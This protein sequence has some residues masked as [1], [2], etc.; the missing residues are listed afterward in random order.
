MWCFGTQI[1]QN[2]QIV[3]VSAESARSA[4]EIAKAPLP[5][6]YGASSVTF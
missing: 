5:V 4:W 6:I 3:L 1:V 2:T